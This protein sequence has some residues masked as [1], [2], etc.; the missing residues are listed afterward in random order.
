RDIRPGF[1]RPQPIAPIAVGQESTETVK[2]WIKRL[3]AA[4]VIEL[5][6]IAA[7]SIGV[8]YFD[9][10]MAGRSQVFVQ[11]TARNDN[12]L[13]GGLRTTRGDARNVLLAGAHKRRRRHWG[14]W[15][16]RLFRD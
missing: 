16:P 4:P 11:Q 9:E 15:V 3:S 13:A 6:R 2:I 1:Y 8:P 10:R 7:V 12:G 14:I 5:M